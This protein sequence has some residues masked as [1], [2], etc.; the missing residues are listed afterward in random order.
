[1]NAAAEKEG[2]DLTKYGDAMTFKVVV[3]SSEVSMSNMASV[4]YDDRT[5]DPSSTSC[6]QG[7]YVVKSEERL[8]NSPPG[9]GFR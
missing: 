1:L 5:V 9:A 3:D 2:I 8:S 6:L 7:D 4:G